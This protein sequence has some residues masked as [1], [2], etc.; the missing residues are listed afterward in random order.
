MMQAETELIHAA[1]QA[2]GARAYRIIWPVSLF[3]AGAWRV[4][5][6]GLLG[7]VDWLLL[8]GRSVRASLLPPHLGNGRGDSD[9]PDSGV[10]GRLDRDRDVAGRL[11]QRVA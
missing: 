7:C 3:L 4:Q 2:L 9:D 8:S 5:S 11:S 1:T 10:S 6:S